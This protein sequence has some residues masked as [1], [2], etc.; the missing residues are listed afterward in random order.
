MASTSTMESS[1]TEKLEDNF[2]DNIMKR[3]W[4]EVVNMYGKYPW[5]RKSQIPSSGQTALHAAIS[6]PEAKY[7]VVRELLEHIKRDPDPFDVLKLKNEKGRTPL[8]L[9]ASTDR[10]VT[11]CKICID[12][13][14]NASELVRDRDSKGRTP[15]F[16]AVKYGR[17]QTFRYLHSIF[18]DF[19]FCVRD[20][21]RSILQEAIIKENFD[22]AFEII[23]L[24][25]DL[26]NQYDEQGESPLH[27]LARK[28]AAFTSGSTTLRGWSKIIYDHSNYVEKNNV[29]FG[30][31]TDIES[32]EVS[33]IAQENDQPLIWSRNTS[34]FG[35]FLNFVFPKM[36]FIF[37]YGD[38]AVR[39]IKAE[40]EKHKWAGQVLE[41]LLNHATMYD[42][43]VKK[44]SVQSPNQQQ[45]VKEKLLQGDQARPGQRQQRGISDEGSDEDFIEDSD[46]LFED[47]ISPTWKDESSKIK[48]KDTALLIATKYGIVEMVEAIIKK[49][50]MAI[51]DEGQDHKNILLVAVENRH[52]KIYKL[53]LNKYSR[54]HVIFHKVETKWNTALHL[55]A[56]YRESVRSWP[57]PGA[58][59]QMQWEIKWLE[60]VENT[61]SPPM[62][63]R[64][65]KEDKTPREIFSSTHKYLVKAGGKW[66]INMAT[67]CSVVAALIVTIAYTSCT[68]VPGG[69]D[70]DSGKRNLRHT[71]TFELFAIASLV[72]LCFSVTSLISFLAILT[73]RHE[74]QDFSKNLPRKILLGLTSLFL[75]IAAMLVTFFAGHFIVFED[76]FKY[77]TFPVYA[78]ILFFPLSIFAAAQFP[79]YIDIFRATFWSPF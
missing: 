66:L 28:P 36:A 72:A 78:V 46:E 52:L 16:L 43:N 76:K 48:K 17:L 40:K 35:Y 50:P 15:L 33:N 6:D 31:N 18:G 37:G 30:T 42:K 5:A 55:A 1:S 70:S 38:T 26:V 11:M 71:P 68:T 47:N 39:K 24:Y 57:V 51:Y 60:F 44:G 9:A 75:S 56:T 27:A 53:L 45:K 10:E 65:N 7:E 20:D 54:K 59:L 79:L 69:T 23:H 58:A 3:E 77:A 25:K 61:M 41:E 22:L 63:L 14:K 29:E 32:G 2:F 74:E 73:S 34:C 19:S 49:F 21:G 12:N 8:H 4:V 13:V 67:S 62:L 64:T